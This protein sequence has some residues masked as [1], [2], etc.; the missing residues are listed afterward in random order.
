MLIITKFAIFRTNNEESESFV[1]TERKFCNLCKRKFGSVEV[2]MKHI[3]MSDL[4]KVLN[5]LFEFP[6]R[7]IPSNLIFIIGFVLFF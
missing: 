6:G 5:F 2:L 1:D 4:H 3:R 7:I